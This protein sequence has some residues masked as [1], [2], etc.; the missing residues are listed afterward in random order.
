MKARAASRRMGEGD[1]RQE[2][3][4][5]RKGAR[6]GSVERAGRESAKEARKAGA[7]G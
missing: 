2:E 1:E 7:A 6:N 4:L 5:A 3:R